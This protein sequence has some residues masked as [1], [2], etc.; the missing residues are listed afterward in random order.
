MLTTPTL[1]PPY[2]SHCGSNAPSNFID[3]ASSIGEDIWNTFDWTGSEHS[4]DFTCGNEMRLQSFNL[5]NRNLVLDASSCAPSQTIPWGQVIK[6]RSTWQ[7]NSFLPQYSQRKSEKNLFSGL[8][9][10]NFQLQ[11][12][13]CVVYILWK[14]NWKQPKNWSLRCRWGFSPAKVK[15]MQSTYISSH[16][17][18]SLNALQGKTSPHAKRY[19][20][21]SCKKIALLHF[22][23]KF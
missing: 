7:P 4:E 10:W 14:W 21:K 8:V 19:T 17:S 11:E 12:E 9:M 20:S 23:S 22:S 6:L 18:S 16:R 1:P 15:Y 3:V 13:L 2:T 5:V